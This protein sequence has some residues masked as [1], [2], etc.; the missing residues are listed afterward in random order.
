MEH[1]SVGGFL[2]KDSLSMFVFVAAINI[3]I[4]CELCGRRNFFGLIRLL[5]CYILPFSI[6]LILKQVQI[7][8]V[9]PFVDCMGDDG[10]CFF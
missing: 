3:V 8:F 6:S 10:F 7:Y 5:Y 2:Y 1:L 4:E 9:K